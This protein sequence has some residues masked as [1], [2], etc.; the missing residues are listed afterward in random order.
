MGHRVTLIEGLYSGIEHRVVP[1]VIE[2]LKIVT[3]R[4]VLRI[5]RFAFE[6]ARCEGRKKIPPRIKRT[7]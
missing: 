3:E 6:Y 2:S 1:G 4:A 5:A 7:S